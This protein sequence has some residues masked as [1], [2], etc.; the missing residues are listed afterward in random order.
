[1]SVLDTAVSGMLANSNWL[2]TISQNVANSNTTGYKNVE[3]E[4]PRSSTPPR[5]RI[6]RAPA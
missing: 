3:T 2:S 1:M 6:P 5:A 4:F